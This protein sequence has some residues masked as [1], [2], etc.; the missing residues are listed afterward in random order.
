MPCRSAP[1]FCRDSKLS[2][3]KFSSVDVDMIFT[4]VKGKERKIDFATFQKALELVAEKK[5]VEYVVR[6]PPPCTLAP[7]FRSPG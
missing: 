4:R 6:A 2:T 7:R 1:E 5:G 3:S